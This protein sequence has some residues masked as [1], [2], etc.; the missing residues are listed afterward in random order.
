MILLPPV[1][2]WVQCLAYTNTQWSQTDDLDDDA[3]ECIDHRERN[4]QN[5]AICSKCYAGEPWYWFG[6]IRHVLVYI[7]ER[8]IL[9][10]FV[11]TMQNSTNKWLLTKLAQKKWAQTLTSYRCVLKVGSEIYLKA[12]RR[13]FENCWRSRILKIVIFDKCF[14]AFEFY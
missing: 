8:N 13:H 5:T 9:E 7:R 2:C 6:A 3:M 14:C 12:E 10:D 11:R 1:V 4:Y